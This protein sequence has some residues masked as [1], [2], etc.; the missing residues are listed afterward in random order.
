MCRSTQKPNNKDVLKTTRRCVVPSCKKKNKLSLH[1]LPFDTKVR[2]KWM[3]FILNEVPDRVS[4]NWVFCSLHFTVDSFS[5]KAQCDIVFLERLK[6]KDDAVPPVL[7]P[8][9]MSVPTCGLLY[10]SFEKFS[11]EVVLI[12]SKILTK[13]IIKIKLCS[14]SGE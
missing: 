7:D 1:C 5:D 8:I 2:K 11:E 12:Q 3:N 9:V 13:Y 14:C 4:K 10:E 6:L